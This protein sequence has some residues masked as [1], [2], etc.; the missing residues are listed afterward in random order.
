MK[1]FVSLFLFSGFLVSCKDDEDGGARSGKSNKAFTVTPIGSPAKDSCG[2]PFLFTGKQGFMY[3]SWIEKFSGKHHLRFS[4][5]ETNDQ[6]SD[7][8]TIASGFPQMTKSGENIIFAWTD[9]KTRSIK[10]VSKKSR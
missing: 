5:L 6:W 2:E 10:T 9:D 1:F 8:T 7:P 3:F 4:T